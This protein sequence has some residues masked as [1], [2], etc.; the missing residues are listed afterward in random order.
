VYAAK[1]AHDKAVSLGHTDKEEARLTDVYIRC[2]VILGNNK[3]LQV[4]TVDEDPSH[5]TPI[6]EILEIFVRVNSGGLILQ[7]SDLL[8]SLLD[9]TWNN[10]Q[11]ELQMLVRDINKK[12]PYE[13]TRDD[14]LKS[15]LLVDGAETRFD[16]LVSDRRLVE[17]LAKKLP[18]HVPAVRTAWETLGCILLDGCR[19]HSE[20]F[21]RGGHNALLPFVAFLSEHAQIANEDRNKL[22]IGIYVAIMSGVFA[23]AEARMGG[24]TRSKVLGA[25]SFPLKELTGLVRREYG[26][27]S[28]D[29]L[30]RRHRDLTLNIAHGGITVDTNPE[31]LQRDHIFPKSSLEKAGLPYERVNH[32]A[33]FHFLRAVDNLNK[34]DRPPD[35]WFKNPGGNAP[36][37]SDKD[38]A[39]RLLTW[40]D[41]PPG[42]FEAM[43]ERRGKKIRE[44]AEKFFGLSEHELN[45]LFAG[46]GH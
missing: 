26:I 42:N 15:L 10:I 31:D 28:L 5:V 32:Y 9:L 11:P 34:L 23:G 33:N 38:L 4:I 7:K 41:L 39:E 27:K 1:T 2:A 19:I 37:Y 8:M 46:A 45:Q 3:S 44:K 22:V 43:I 24:F 29:D 16:R 18:A 13:F 25:S 21:F 12:R 35:E 14:V 17:D 6:E 30:L 20:R 40:D 36:P